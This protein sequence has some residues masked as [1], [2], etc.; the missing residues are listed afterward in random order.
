MNNAALSYLQFLVVD[1]TI[2]EYDDTSASAPYTPA[3]VAA[4]IVEY[5]ASGDTERT[6]VITIVQSILEALSSGR[7]SNSGIKLPDDIL[8]I[9]HM[10]TNWTVDG[11]MYTSTANSYMPEFTIAVLMELVQR[12]YVFQRIIMESQTQFRD[13]YL[14]VQTNVWRDCAFSYPLSYRVWDEHNHAIVGTST[15][16]AMYNSWLQKYVKE[17]KDVHVIKRLT[18]NIHVYY[19][20][21]RQNGLF[22]SYYTPTDVKVPAEIALDLFTRPPNSSEL[23]VYFEE[24][25]TQSDFPCY[26]RLTNY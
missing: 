12:E 2:G 17:F 3:D 18:R 4:G 20:S 21:S 16:Q 25:E 19:R 22:M 24:T 9:D 15:R 13:C 8:D 1:R 5:M 26:I 6:I 14:Q 11:L 23:G 10:N 7:Y